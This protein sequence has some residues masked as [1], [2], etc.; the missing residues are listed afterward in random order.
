ML[1]AA[2][3]GFGR[4]ITSLLF[5]SMLL[6]QQRRVKRVAARA[7]WKSDGH[8]SQWIESVESRVMLTGSDNFVARTDLGSVASVTDTGTNVAYTGRRTVAEQYDQFCMVVV[9]GSF[10][11]DIG[12][13]HHWQRL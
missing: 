6:G 7:P 2:A 12:G 1:I 4:Q 8:V 11:R 13:G 10:Q 9:D 5:R 3:R